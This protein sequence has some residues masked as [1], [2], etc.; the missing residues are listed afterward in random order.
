M[1]GA[2]GYV[3]GVSLSPVSAGW[4]STCG[5]CIGATA[6]LQLDVAGPRSSHCWVGLQLVPCVCHSPVV[7]GWVCTIGCDCHSPGYAGWVCTGGPDQGATPFYFSVLVGWGL[8]GTALPPVN[9]EWL[10]PIVTPDNAE[11]LCEHGT[12]ASSPMWLLGTCTLS[13]PRT[14]LACRASILLCQWLLATLSEFVCSP[15]QCVFTGS[16]GINWYHT[17]THCGRCTSESLSP[18]SICY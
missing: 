6:V 8:C 15:Q 16:V 18:S 5:P 4:V 10:L 14:G 3:C 2:E 12:T 7:T 13:C 11:W 9:A 1:L 17:L